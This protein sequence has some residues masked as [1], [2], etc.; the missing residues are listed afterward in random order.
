MC[1]S[2]C[3]LRQTSHRSIDRLISTHK[4]MNIKCFLIWT[5]T[6]Y[7]VVNLN[8][9]LTPQ[10]YIRAGNV[11]GRYTLTWCS[12]DKPPSCSQHFTTFHE[13]ESSYQLSPGS[14]GGVLDVVLYS[15]LPEVSRRGFPSYLPLYGVWHLQNACQSIITNCGSDHGDILTGEAVV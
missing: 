1:H 15:S 9:I 3:L 5:T 10:F 14:S 12:L 7:C 13:V 11:E 8:Y 4:I 6:C 2:Y